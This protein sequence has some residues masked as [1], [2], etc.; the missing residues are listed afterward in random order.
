MRQIYGYGFVF[1]YR[2]YYNRIERKDKGREIL[3]FM[4][5]D[6]VWCQAMPAAASIFIFILSRTKIYIFLIK[7]LDMF[8]YYY[9]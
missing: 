3:W 2:Q 9:F 6:C 4:G 8:D 1:T 7:K 5:C